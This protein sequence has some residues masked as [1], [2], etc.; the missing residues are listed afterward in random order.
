[1]GRLRVFPCTV[2]I[3]SFV[4][5]P[6]ALTGAVTYAVANIVTGLLFLNQ[7]TGLE[8]LEGRLVGLL[9]QELT[10]PGIV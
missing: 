10:Q 7:R 2:Q 1:M 9:V 3:V 6:C 4:V 5:M 8:R